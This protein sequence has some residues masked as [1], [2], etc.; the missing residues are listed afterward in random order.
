MYLSQ[1]TEVG[2]MS[3]IILGGTG[4]QKNKQLL[5][6]S[7]ILFLGRFV[8]LWIECKV[9]FNCGCCFFVFFT[10]V[11][12]LHEPKRSHFRWKKISL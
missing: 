7:C 11:D 1:V 5:V 12:V 3:F 9:Y 4:R 8:I 6:Y 2:Q 10:S